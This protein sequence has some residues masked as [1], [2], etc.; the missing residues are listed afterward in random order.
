MLSIYILRLEQNKY[1][2][3]KTTN[4]KFRIENHVDMNGS[5][6]TKKYKPIGIDNIIPDCDDYD[7]NKYTILYMDRYGIDNVRGGSFCNVKLDDSTVNFILSMINGTNDK[8]FGCGVEGHFVKDCPEENREDK[9]KLDVGLDELPFEYTIDNCVGRILN[10]VKEHFPRKKLKIKKIIRNDECFIVS[11]GGKFCPL[12]EDKHE[13]SFCYFEIYKTN[14]IL[15]CRNEECF[16]KHYP[17]KVVEYDEKL[18]EALFNFNEN[19]LSTI[20]RDILDISAEDEYAKIQVS[21]DETYNRLIAKSLSG[22]PCDIALFAFY[23]AK[24]RF[25]CTNDKVWYVFDGHTWKTAGATSEIYTYLSYNTHS[26]Y[27]KLMEYFKTSEKEYFSKKICIEKIMRD[28]KTTTHKKNIFSELEILMMRYDQDFEGKLNKNP[29]IIGF[30][31]GIY[32]LIK[33]EFRNGNPDDFVSLTCGYDYSPTM[34][35]NVSKL[36]ETISDILPDECDRDY[37]L[38]YISTTLTGINK[39]ELFTVLHGKGRNGK[40]LIMK[41]LGDTLGSYCN[42]LSS[43]MLTGTIPES[44]APNPTLYNLFNSRLVISSECSSK[45]KL[46]MGIIKILTGNDEIEIRKLYCN[47]PE[48]FKANFKILFACNDIPNVDGNIDYAFSTRLRCINFPTVFVKNP[49]KDNE[50]LIN[51]NLKEFIGDWKNDFMNIM[52]QYYDRYTSGGLVPSANILRLTGNYRDD[53]NIYIIYLNEMVE[54][55]DSVEGRKKH[56]ISIADFYK[57]FHSWYKRSYPRTL[58]PSRIEF[59]R[60]MSNHAVLKNT[61]RIG[62]NILCGFEGVRI[63]TQN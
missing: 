10:S 33:K 40:S 17:N 2:I 41:L 45:D 18:S 27:K 56:R 53:N 44:N 49:K 9:E 11:V 26:H 37:F 54:L 13:D 63:K 52:I 3:G 42:F 15:R 57:N 30:N 43:K 8:C 6:W 36:M 28:L 35:E 5:S 46:N 24:E 60:G 7:E 51:E 55:F 29:Y 22:T 21:D 38:T 58:V 12:I 50:R 32:D 20:G 1:Y 61:L 19:P 47:K 4:P 31:N 16:G 59:R 34:S 39:D 23:G 62:K 14:L 48:K 25:R